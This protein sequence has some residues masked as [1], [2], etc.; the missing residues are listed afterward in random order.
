MIREKLEDLVQLADGLESHFNKYPNAFRKFGETGGWFTYINP[1]RQT[2]IDVNVEENGYVYIS[3]NGH[4]MMFSDFEHSGWFPWSKR[5]RQLRESRAK[6][7]KI[8][9]AVNNK[10]ATNLHDL[11]PELAQEKLEEAIWGKKDE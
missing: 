8:C 2:E 7:Y 10:S 4:S 3:L 5:T 9:M 1:H 6:L 11:F